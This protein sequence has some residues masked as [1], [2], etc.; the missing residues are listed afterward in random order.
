MSEQKRVKHSYVSDLSLPVLVER[1]VSLPF[2]RKQTFSLRFHQGTYLKSHTYVFFFSYGGR[3]FQFN[4]FDV[5]DFK[6]VFIGQSEEE[7]T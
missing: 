6:V 3:H 4:A 5:A 1:K 7:L 2:Q